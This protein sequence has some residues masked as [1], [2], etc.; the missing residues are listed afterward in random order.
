MSA[1]PCGWAGLVFLRGFFISMDD[2]RVADRIWAFGLILFNLARSLERFLM[3]N[4]VLT[5]PNAAHPDI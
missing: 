3:G 2:A 5:V 1:S 4:S